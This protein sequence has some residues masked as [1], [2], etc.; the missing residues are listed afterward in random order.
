MKLYWRMP[1]ISLCLFKIPGSSLK[2]RSHYTDLVILAH[3]KTLVLLASIK[4]VLEH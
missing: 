2:S 3:F 4:S 1:N